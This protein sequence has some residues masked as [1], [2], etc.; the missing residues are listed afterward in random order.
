MSQFA[1]VERQTK[2]VLF[3]NLTFCGAIA[4]GACSAAGPD[5]STQS[6]PKIEDPTGVEE[7]KVLV[8]ELELEENRKI[9]F[10]E[11]RPG[12]LQIAEF[13]DLGSTVKVTQE[14]LARQRSYVEIYKELSGG[15]TAPL[16]LVR[17]EARRG[18]FQA[19]L[20]K[21]VAEPIK[22]PSPTM[23][24][25]V[26][27]AAARG[28]NAQSDYDAE[29]AA[30]MNL[31]CN[32]AAQTYRFCL[33]NLPFPESSQFKLVFEGVGSGWMTIIQYCHQTTG[34][35]APMLGYDMGGGLYFYDGVT[36][37]PRQFA[38]LHSDGIAV[39]GA[40]FNGWGATGDPGV[41][42][43]F[44]MAMHWTPFPTPS[45]DCNWHGDFCCDPYSTGW[46][47]CDTAYD[48]FLHCDQASGLCVSP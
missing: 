41:G 31:A 11:V 46:G 23:E 37:P 18:A 2:S 1:K 19:K 21:P 28:P 39:R 47:M 26:E 40:R 8:A 10:W 5:S 42:T 44:S 24:R 15:R 13:G 22:T 14:M 29:A 35:C 17:A 7:Q 32:P 43:R 27:S 16:E 9:Q 12:L 20:A 34:S 33:G 38:V 30:F 6:T 45:G 25:L 36:V 4:L 48:S 3:T